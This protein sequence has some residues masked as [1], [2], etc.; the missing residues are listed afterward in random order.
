MSDGVVKRAR[1]HEW[2]LT[3]NMSL[4]TIRFWIEADVEFGGLGSLAEAVAAVDR[5]VQA[6]ARERADGKLVINDGM[7]VAK[8][9]AELVPAANSVEVVNGGGVGAC[10]HRDWP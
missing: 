4:S 1:V 8:R 2:R 3:R 7:A 10:V 5:G 9:L 6:I